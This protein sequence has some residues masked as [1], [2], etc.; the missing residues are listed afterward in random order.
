LANLS[1]F[2]TPQRDPFFETL[3]SL[4]IG[5]LF[6]SISATVTPSSLLIHRYQSGSRVI[7]KAADGAIAAGSDLLSLIHRGRDLRPVRT[8]GALTPE[9]GDTAIL[10]GPS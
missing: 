9:P 2:R 3:V 8:A 5:L 6:L 7:T 4:F 10:L 1:L